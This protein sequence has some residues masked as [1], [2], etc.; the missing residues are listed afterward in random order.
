MTPP[1]RRWQKVDENTEAGESVFGKIA[2]RIW[3]IVCIFGAII[4]AAKLF[5]DAPTEKAAV[6]AGIGAVLATL[7]YH[8]FEKARGAPGLIDFSE[9]SH[10]MIAIGLGLALGLS[11][12]LLVNEIRNER[13]A[14]AAHQAS[15]KEQEEYNEKMR[16]PEMQSAIEA[17]QRIREMRERRAS[18]GPATN[19]ATGNAEP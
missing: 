12:L 3:G 1:R 17:M 18:T 6:A 19:P 2:F 13:N 10:R 8:A 11:V 7:G 5:P 14:E 15:Q 4:L 16:S 9:R